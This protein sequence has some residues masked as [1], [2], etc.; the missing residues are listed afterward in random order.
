MMG[1]T[2]VDILI[3]LLPMLL[4]IGAWFFFMR[5]FTGPGSLQSRQF[6]LNER[7]VRALE[8]IADALEKRS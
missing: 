3:G 6:E 7:Q 4:L 8:R 2:L 1:P 5:R